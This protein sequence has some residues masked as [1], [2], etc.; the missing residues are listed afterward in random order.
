MK[1]SDI[2]SS[3]NG[4]KY[5]PITPAVSFHNVPDSGNEKVPFCPFYKAE[6]HSWFPQYIPFPFLFVGKTGFS[7]KIPGSETAGWE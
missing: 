5:S 3:K 7:G 1:C 6:S 2:F 4:K